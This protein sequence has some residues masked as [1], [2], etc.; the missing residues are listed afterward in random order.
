MLSDGAPLGVAPERLGCRA[1]GAAWLTRR[2]AARLPRRTFGEAYALGAEPPGAADIARAQAYAARI[3]RLW[4]AAS[5]AS[6][7]DVG[8][9]N[10]ALLLALRKAWPATRGLGVEPAARPAAA[11]RAAGLGV[12][13]ALRPGLRATLVVA[14]NVVE[15]TADPVVFLA[16]LRRAMAPGGA[17][18][19]ICPDGTEPWLE[20]L[21]ADHRWSLTPAALQRAAASAGLRVAAAEPAPGGFQAVLLRAAPRRTRQPAKGATPATARRRYMGHWRALDATLLARASTGRRLICFGAGEA[22][23]LLRA[24]APGIWARVAAV[25]A[26]DQ[27]GAAG[28]RRPVLDPKELR[29]DQDDILLAVRPAAQAGLAER[30]AARGFTV[31]RWDDVVPR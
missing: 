2:Q 21:M 26:D 27:A 12:L 13:P 28:L 14:V 23:R 31:L 19:V 9:N 30:F 22:A 11:A 17:C 1:C 24:Y 25:A 20:L 7:L 6:V 16:G 15:H 10:G 8:C 18:I 29:M 3:A 4:G 5:P